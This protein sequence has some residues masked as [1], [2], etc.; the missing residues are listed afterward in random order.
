MLQMLDPNHNVLNQQ[1]APYVLE[2]FHGQP[3]LGSAIPLRGGEPGIA[4]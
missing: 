2:A 4:I 1:Y 3:L